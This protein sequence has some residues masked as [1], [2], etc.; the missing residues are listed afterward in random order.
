[1]EEIIY[2]IKILGLCCAMGFVAVGALLLSLEKSGA[3]ISDKI[4]EALRI[5]DRKKRNEAI[6]REINGKGS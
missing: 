1:M 4:R 3:P 2:Q 6:K 5:K